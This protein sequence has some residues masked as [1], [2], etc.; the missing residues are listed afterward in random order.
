MNEHH[1]LEAVLSTLVAHGEVDEHGIAD[2]LY[3]EEYSGRPGDVE[4]DPLAQW[5]EDATGAIRV[6]LDCYLIEVVYPDGRIDSEYTPTVVAD[7]L[8]KFDF[9]GYPNL[10]G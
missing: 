7:F 9:G 5:I 3:R 1:T 2:L 6:H 10:V 8:D 4:S